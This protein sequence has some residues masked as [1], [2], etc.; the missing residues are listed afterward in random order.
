M[1][2]GPS[3]ATGAPVAFPLQLAQLERLG[4][5][6]LRRLAVAALFAIVWMW[7]LFALPLHRADRA[8]VRPA[9]TAEFA[10]PSHTS[11]VPGTDPDLDRD[12]ADGAVDLLGNDVTDAV[13]RYS[14]D[15]TGSLYEVHSP[16]TE[17]PKL[18]SPK[19]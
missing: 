6:T 5:N 1:A 9:K 16:Q 13:A 17:I 14:L 2:T 3:P 11:A 15:A 4:L 7:A 8:P 10:Q 12:A 19:S 18:G